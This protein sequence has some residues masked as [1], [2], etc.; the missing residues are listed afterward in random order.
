MRIEGLHEKGI[1]EEPFPFRV[2]VD[3]NPHF[4][5]PSHWHNAY[6]IIYVAE[7]SFIVTVNAQRY[8]LDKGDILFIPGGHIHTCE[9]EV[10]DGVRVFIN[11]ELEDFHCY[12]SME[13]AKSCLS[14]EQLITPANLEVYPRIVSEI[15]KILQF[16]VQ[17]ESVGILYY[18]ARILD[19]L[20]LLC[21]NASMRQTMAAAGLNKGKK[22]V[23]LQKIS[24]SLTFIQENYMR[25]IHLRDVAG[26]AGFSEY[27][28]ARLF[29]ET[30]EKSFHWYLNAYRVKKA[31]ALLMDST[32]SIGDVAQAVGFN[33]LITFDRVFHQ[34]KGCS[35]EEF[36]KLQVRF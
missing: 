7:Q 18:I 5:Y 6:E 36:R 22:K 15:K 35:P 29:K 13:D 21:H 3:R 31:E 28:F 14:A 30:T 4:H 20:V 9:G 34:L 26:A 24:K 32:Y 23:G 33:S 17:K 2:I 16:N 10:P 11:F 8:V 19:I 1:F 25:D 27:Y 12:L